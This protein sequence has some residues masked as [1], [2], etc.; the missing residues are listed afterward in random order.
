M[1]LEELAKHAAEKGFWMSYE[2]PIRS[3]VGADHSIGFWLHG[4]TMGDPP[5]IDIAAAALP[6][7]I[8]L[9][10]RSLEKAAQP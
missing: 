2:S 5:D 10:V 6:E 1:T 9:A 4:K 3:G 8:R 7:C